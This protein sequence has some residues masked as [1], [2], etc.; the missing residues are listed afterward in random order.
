MRGNS[1]ALDGRGVCDF[2]IQWRDLYG[3]VGRGRERVSPGAA[4]RSRDLW[5]KNGSRIW[6]QPNVYGYPLPI[7]SSIRLTP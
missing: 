5:H 1:G 3:T 4:A 2:T 7:S 6:T